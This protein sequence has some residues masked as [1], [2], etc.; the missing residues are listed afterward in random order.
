MKIKI[1]DKM[2]KST[3]VFRISSED[4]VFIDKKFD[5]LHEQSKLK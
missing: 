5:V 4:K 3:R 1:T 2:S